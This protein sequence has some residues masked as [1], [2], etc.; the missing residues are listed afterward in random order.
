MQLRYGDLSQETPCL[1]TADLAP[2]VCGNYS[3]DY[4]FPIAPV[5]G[6]SES[7]A[8]LHVANVGRLFRMN[9][10]SRPNSTGNRA[11]IH[12]AQP[13]MLPY[14]VPQHLTSPLPLPKI[15]RAVTCRFPHGSSSTTQAGASQSPIHRHRREHC[16]CPHH[17]SWLR[18]RL[19]SAEWCLGL[20]AACAL[21]RAGHGVVVVEKSDGQARVRSNLRSISRESLTN[22]AFR[23][24]VA[25]GTLSDIRREFVQL[26][27]IVQL[28]LTTEHDQNPAKLGPRTFLEQD[29]RKVH[30]GQYGER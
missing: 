19:L 18:S 9:P 4:A 1:C 24:R 29:L 2:H 21:R 10:D 13:F 22:L 16:R 23:A 7:L 20:G 3:Q 26:I 27:G 14:S 8:K 25:F 5:Y 11:F 6:P 17:A 28:Q 12:E 30:H 15:P